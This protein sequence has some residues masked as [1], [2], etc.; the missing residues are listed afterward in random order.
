MLQ[1]REG[2]ADLVPRNIQSEVGTTASTLQPNHHAIMD[3]A[4]GVVIG[5]SLVLLAILFQRPI[6]KILAAIAY[7][8]AKGS[9]LRVDSRWGSFELYEEGQIDTFDD[10]DINLIDED[11]DSDKAAATITNDDERTS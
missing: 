11:D 3:A 8:I 4:P 7:R 6:S 5:F 9:T 10:L 1:S 2:Q